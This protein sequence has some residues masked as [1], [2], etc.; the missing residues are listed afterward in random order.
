MHSF[1]PNVFKKL[2]DVLSAL[3]ADPRLSSLPVVVLTSSEV[4]LDEVQGKAVLHKPIE[5]RELLEL[6]RTLC[7]TDV[8]LNHAM[9]SAPQSFLGAPVLDAGSLQRR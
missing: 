3:R 6:V 8:A 9:S 4:P 7:G 2:L 5:E 1:T